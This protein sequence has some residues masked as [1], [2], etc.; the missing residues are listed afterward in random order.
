M[1]WHIDIPVLFSGPHTGLHIA[2]PW[3]SLCH[4]VATIE[5]SSSDLNTTPALTTESQLNR[6]KRKKKSCTVHK[7]K[8]E[9]K[10]NLSSTFMEKKYSVGQLCII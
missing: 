2:V 9:K 7:F 1:N 8:E 4:S 5:Y 10:L 3:V 6:L